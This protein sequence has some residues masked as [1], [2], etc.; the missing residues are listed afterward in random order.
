VLAAGRGAQG[1]FLC[2]CHSS[3]YDLAGR[4]FRIGPAP[5]NLIIPVYR[6]EG[7]RRIVLGEA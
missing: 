6:L 3:K 4:V 1:E 7:D 2:P 5:A